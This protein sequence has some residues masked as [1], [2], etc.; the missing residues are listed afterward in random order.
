MTYFLK[1]NH[2]K[3]LSIV[4]FNLWTKMKILKIVLT[5]LLVSC[6]I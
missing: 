1:P 6:I 5:S 2:I 4:I 3:S